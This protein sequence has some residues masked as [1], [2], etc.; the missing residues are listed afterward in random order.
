MTTQTN[1]YFSN[2]S[3]IATEV[4]NEKYAK[5]EP[6][7][8]YMAVTI[9]FEN[10]EQVKAIT[11]AKNTIAKQVSEGTLGQA[12]P[13]TTPRTPRQP[14]DETPVAH[15]AAVDPLKPAT[16]KRIVT[17][18]NNYDI[19]VTEK[20]VAAA[21][22][23]KPDA[24]FKKVFTE[25]LGDTAA[26]FTKKK[27]HLLVALLVVLEFTTKDAQLNGLM[28]AALKKAPKLFEELEAEEEEDE[29]Q[30]EDNDDA[31]VP[32]DDEEEDDEEDNADDDADDKWEAEEDEDDYSE[33]TEAELRAAAVE[34]GLTSKTNAKK[35]TEEQLLELLRASDEEDDEEEEEEDDDVIEVK[36]GKK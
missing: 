15:A 18:M 36:K 23:G 27:I 25:N 17:L 5:A 32:S 10:V 4:T 31:D 8:G 22:E 13:A 7:E 33:M 28:E 1:V 6:K 20:Q 2:A 29:E 14:K 19:K 21:W 16:I 24:K 11:K 12:A 26:E 35:L 30:E 34:Q 3:G 9:V